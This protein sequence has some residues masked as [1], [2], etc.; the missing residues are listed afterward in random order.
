MGHADFRVAG[1]IFASLGYPDVSRAMVKLP[2]ED[3]V[4]L[5]RS[6][7]TGFAPASGAW[8]R[9]GA[10]LVQLKIAPKRTVR[11]ALE[12]AHAAVASR[13]GRFRGKASKPK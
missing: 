2:Q 11:A 3:Q 8:G 13:D 9:A 1:R 5:L 6:C 10:T 4:F 12:I 7:E